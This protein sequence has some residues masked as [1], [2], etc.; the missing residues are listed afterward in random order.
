ML[1][2]RG[3][4]VFDTHTRTSLAK[5]CSDKGLGFKVYFIVVQVSTCAFRV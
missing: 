1:G 3:F 5:V 4:K 2:C